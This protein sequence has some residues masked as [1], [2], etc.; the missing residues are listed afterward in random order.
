MTRRQAA[1]GSVRV[2]VHSLFAAALLLPQPEL[3][4]ESLRKAIKQA[5]TALPEM[6]RAAKA[7][8]RPDATQIVADLCEKEVAL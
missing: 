2:G 4:A 1:F 7:L 3:N 8:S 6:S 5:M